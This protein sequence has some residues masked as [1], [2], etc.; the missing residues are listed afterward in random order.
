MD[1]F[2]D[3][4]VQKMNAQEMIRANAAAD[5][6]EIEKLEKKTS[7]LKQQLGEYEA[8]IQEMRQMNSKNAE[9]TEN[10]LKLSGTANQLI[11]ESAAKA[12]EKL[13][14]SIDTIG[15]KLDNAAEAM[16]SRIKNMTSQIDEQ[17]MT[18]TKNS[19]EQ[20]QKMVEASLAKIEEIQAASQN[21]EEVLTR[22]DE[23]KTELTEKF[24]KNEEFVHV[25]NVKVYRNVQAAVV[26]ELAKQ[27]D[28]L[29]AG[30]KAS[31]G[32]YKVMLPMIIIVMIC[33][34]ANLGI[35]IASIL[36][37]I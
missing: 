32:G 34:F 4:L 23:L 20:V 13:N 24:A 30:Q 16:D 9:C 14:G 27:T 12:G 28:T 26:E 3:K 8:C 11:E 21:P 19:S 22:L 10:I 15:I 35:L 6:T 36:G 25:E 29:L 33:T 18:S 7:E 17:L 37:L 1:N 5:A 31:A 2:M